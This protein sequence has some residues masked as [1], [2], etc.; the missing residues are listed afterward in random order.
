LEM[1]WL[2][3][4]VVEEITQRA[5]YF[6]GRFCVFAFA[7]LLICKP[8]VQMDPRLQHFLQHTADLW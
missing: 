8:S 1:H 3:E 5:G 4:G 7:S 6:L 2:E